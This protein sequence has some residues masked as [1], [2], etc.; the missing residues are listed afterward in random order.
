MSAAKSDVAGLNALFDFYKNLTTHTMSLKK[1]AGEGF[2]LGM[3]DSLLGIARLVRKNPEVVEEMP[4]VVEDLRRR[5][6][7]CAKIYARH[8]AV[9]KEKACLRMGRWLQ[10]RAWSRDFKKDK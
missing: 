8:G 10:V 5:L 9:V 3:A 2:Y 4:E 7:L 6:R 1:S